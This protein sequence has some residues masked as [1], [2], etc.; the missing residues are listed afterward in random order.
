MAALIRK[1]DPRKWQE[2]EQRRFSGSP[3]LRMTAAVNEIRELP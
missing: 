3:S 2:K 1:E